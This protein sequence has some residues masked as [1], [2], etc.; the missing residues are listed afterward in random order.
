[1]KHT[2]KKKWGKD[3]IQLLIGVAIIAI[4]FYLKYKINKGG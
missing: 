1:M 2:K 3:L 4:Y